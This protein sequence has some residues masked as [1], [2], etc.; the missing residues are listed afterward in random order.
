MRSRFT[1]SKTM[2][3]RAIWKAEIVADTFR[4]PV[5]LYSVVQDKSVRFRLLHEPDLQPVYQQ[6][7]DPKRKR[8]VP[9]E[10]IQRGVEV[11]KGV[12]VVISEEEQAALEPEESR[13]IVIDRVVDRSIMDDR[14]FDH[15]YF[16]GPDGDP[17]PYFALVEALD[18]DRLAIAEWTMR[19]QRHN[20]AL[21]CAD[22]YLMLE[23]LRSAEEVFQIEPIGV[24]ASRA[25]EPRE[26]KLAEQLI[27]GLKDTFDPDEWQDEYREQVLELIDLKASGKIVQFPKYRKAAPKGSL[28]ENLEASLKQGRKRS[29]AKRA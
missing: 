24:P 25:P 29:N 22:G 6:M 26:L 11:E 28:L 19:K 16:L 12:F 21:H 17:T 2:A 7:I 8:P 20:G 15:P 3:A 5:K 14:W 4:V 1:R 10:E 9:S 13:E 27:S 18:D 23:T